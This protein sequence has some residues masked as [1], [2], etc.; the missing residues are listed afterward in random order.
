M[1]K[2]R[3]RI[4]SILT[5]DLLSRGLGFITSVY[6]A[7]T[8][9]AEDFGFLTVA[10]SIL[11]YQLLFSDMG[12]LTIGA[13][14]V[15]KRPIKRIYRAREVLFV[16][17]VMGTLVFLAGLVVLPALDMPDRQL[18]L[19][20][21]FSFSLIPYAILTEWYFNGTQA[22]HK[23]ALSRVT[24]S[25]IYFTGVYILV[26]SSGD[27]LKIPYIY[28]AGIMA[29]AV[30]IGI[31][32]FTDRS[33]FSLPARGFAVF[34]D[35]LRS[36]FRIGLGSFFNQAIPLLPPLLIGLFIS[37]YDAGIYGAAI[38]IILIAMMIDRVFVQLLLPN[39][40]AKWSEDKEKAT[41]H[42]QIVSRLFITLGIII[43]VTIAVGSEQLI[44]LIYG[45]AYSE[46]A[47]LLPALSVMVTATFMNSIFAYGLVAIGRDNEYFLST[48]IGGLCT[49]VLIGLGAFTKDLNLVIYAVVL[50]ELCFVTAAFVQ[51]RKFIKIRLTPFFVP[52]VLIGATVLYLYHYLNLGYIVE[53]VSAPLVVLF[54]FWISRV[55]KNADIKWMW[56][57]I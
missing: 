15:A 17:M 39:L 57:K 18:R 38:K 13:R 33:A 28:T 19:A 34:T 1:T 42:L 4:L 32:A 20:L 5:G 47:P 35:L 51:F 48:V 54:L 8:L 9:G 53:P 36:S 16:K 11:G 27:L 25:I 24:H 43:T 29:S 22:F 10:L 41:E 56:Q 50:A 6:L 44:D 26:D 45:P 40:A 3:N 55:L 21:L 30:L 46:S 2:L 52:A 31:I 37:E 14:E 7:R 49:I 23:V 12:L